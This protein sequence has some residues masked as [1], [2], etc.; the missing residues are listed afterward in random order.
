M[1]DRSV[2]HKTNGRPGEDLGVGWLFFLS[3]NQTGCVEHLL[4]LQL[5]NT[6]SHLYNIWTVM[7]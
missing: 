1:T 4:E 3:T 6:L 7:L 5:C 2:T